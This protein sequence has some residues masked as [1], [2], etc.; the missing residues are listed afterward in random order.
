[1][2]ILFQ[3]GWKE[4]RNTPESKVL[5]EDYCLTLARYIIKER[6]TIVLT[7]NGA[8][9][10]VIADELAA[11][12][13]PEGCN[14]KDHL[15]YFL[16]ELEHPLPTAGRVVTI[17]GK[18]W[19]IEE[20]TYAVQN[21]DALIAIGGGKGTLDCVQKAFLSNK[22]VF[23]AA[24]IP[25]ASSNAWKTRAKGYRYVTDGDADT[26]DDVNVSPEEF[27]RNVFGIL[28]ALAEKIYSRRVF[29]VHGHDLH[30]RDQLAYLLRKLEFEPVILQ[31][32]A[33]KGLT[34]IEKLERDT[35]KVGF[36]FVLYTPDDL[37]RQHGGIEKER[38]RQNV[39]FEHGL[40]IGLLGRERTCAIVKGAIE[41][42]SDIGGMIYERIGDLKAEAIK[43][44]RV[45]KD[46]GYKL[47]PSKL[48]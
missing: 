3:G 30:F 27:F 44:A 19:L 36:S 40:L 45:L 21:T 24:A 17:P 33:N 37:G 29:I 23:V 47:D 28:N 15:L 48:L 43:I 34:I 6:H 32:E 31:E 20:R 7:S 10:K 38:A 39:I 13:T 14:V 41:I 16:P 11:A 1:M 2:K 35:G 25:S 4:E 8:F 26:F 12:A 9:D 22:P 42:P 46:A 5:I 18:S